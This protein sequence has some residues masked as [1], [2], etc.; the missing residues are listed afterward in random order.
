ML[1]EEYEQHES[2]LEFNVFYL[3][4]QVEDEELLHVLYCTRLVLLSDNYLLLI[5]THYQYIHIKLCEWLGR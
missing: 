2:G 4:S 3:M 1:I 5:R